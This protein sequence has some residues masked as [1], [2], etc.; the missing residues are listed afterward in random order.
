MLRLDF[1]L[2]VGVFILI[3]SASRGFFFLVTGL[4]P[5]QTLFFSSTLLI[6]ILIFLFSNPIKFYKYDNY[7]LFKNLIYLNLFTGF[8]LVYN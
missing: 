3:L 7:H 8:F 5:T 2:Y 4:P 1:K 6:F